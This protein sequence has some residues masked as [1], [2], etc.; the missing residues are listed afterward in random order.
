MDLNFNG[1]Y[2]RNQI[3][4]TILPTEQANFLTIIPVISNFYSLS[5][6]IGRAIE[7]LNAPSTPTNQSYRRLSNSSPQKLVFAFFIYKN[8]DLALTLT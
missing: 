1:V 5:K 2:R 3:G 6:R 4:K 8:K 7:M